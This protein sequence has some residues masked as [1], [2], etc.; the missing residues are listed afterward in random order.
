MD[1][2]TKK[3]INEYFHSELPQISISDWNI[4]LD[5]NRNLRQSLESQK[6][7]I[8]ILVSEIERLQKYIV[9]L[10]KRVDEH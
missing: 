7:Q 9:Q 8:E 6:N 5:E 2:R 3:N 1:N 4:L 10:T